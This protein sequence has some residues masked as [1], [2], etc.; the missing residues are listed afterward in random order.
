MVQTHLSESVESSEEFVE[1][2]DQFGGSVGGRNSG[3][4]HDIR[5]Q[6]AAKEEKIMI[7][8]AL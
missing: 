7:K 1:H 8:T 5:K 6:D 2:F 4:P 3:E